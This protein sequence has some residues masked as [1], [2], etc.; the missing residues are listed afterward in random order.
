MIGGKYGSKS[1]PVPIEGGGDDEGA[2]EEAGPSL[3]DMGLRRAAKGLLSAIDSG[4]AG[5]VAK[6]L[7]AAYEACSG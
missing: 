6:A 5:A 7:K 2:E 1:E 4:D 3:G